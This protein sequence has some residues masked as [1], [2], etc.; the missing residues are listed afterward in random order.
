[1]GTVGRGYRLFIR[2]RTYFQGSKIGVQSVYKVSEPT[3]RE[4]F[5][6]VEPFYTVSEPDSRGLSAG[7]AA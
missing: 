7:S 5:A 2:V 6:W 3:S 1:M 4:L